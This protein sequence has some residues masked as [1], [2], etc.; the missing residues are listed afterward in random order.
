MDTTRPPPPKTD[1]LVKYVFKLRRKC[2]Y[3]WWKKVLPAY[4]HF[5]TIKL[6]LDLKQ[7]YHVFLALGGS[8]CILDFKF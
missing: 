1:I 5:K 7:K 2:P 8:I 3:Y 6:K 4:C